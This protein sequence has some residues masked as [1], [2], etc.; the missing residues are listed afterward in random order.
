[1]SQLSKKYTAQ[2]EKYLAGLSAEDRELLNKKQR[3]AEARSRE[4]WDDVRNWLD[5]ESIGN[6]HHEEAVKILRTAIQ[7]AADHPDMTKEVKEIADMFLL[8]FNER[9]S[10]NY[11][12]DAFF[13]PVIKIG[14]SQGRS[15]NARKAGRAR[16]ERDDKTQCLNEIKGEAI[17][18]C[19]QFARYGYRAQ[20]IREVMEK[21]P[22]LEDDKAIGR[23]LINLTSEGLIPEHK[24]KT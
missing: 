13:E 1:M 5:K 8:L 7:S 22:N 21:Y 18:Q 12:S 2:R 16:A 11:D 19:K 23:L 6:A 15:K 9:L 10:F 20:F 24:K 4:R 17:Q 14:E 3:E